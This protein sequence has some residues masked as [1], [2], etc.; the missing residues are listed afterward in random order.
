MIQRC[1][2]LL[3]HSCPRL[4][5][6]GRAEEWKGLWGEARGLQ[7]PSSSGTG[8]KHGCSLLVFHTLGLVPTVPA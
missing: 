6:L 5:C 2:W 3:Q 8:S 7:G 4:D 1:W